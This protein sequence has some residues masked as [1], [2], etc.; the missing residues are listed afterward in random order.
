[1]PYLSFEFD[2]IGSRRDAELFVYIW[3]K[4]AFGKGTF[5]IFH[6]Y[7]S[8][9]LVRLALNDSLSQIELRARLFDFEAQRL[10]LRRMS[11]TVATVLSESRRSQLPD[12]P[13]FHSEL[14]S[15][16]LLWTIA[17]DPPSPPPRPTADQ[18]FRIQVTKYKTFVPLAMDLCHRRCSTSEGKR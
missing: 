7:I 13:R 16:F 11:N 10:P 2:H 15:V 6:M 8:C 5:P 18:K 17:R 4:Q 14:E 1:M 3:E 12:R 9:E